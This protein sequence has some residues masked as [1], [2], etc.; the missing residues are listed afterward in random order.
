MVLGRLKFNTDSYGRMD[1]K[2]RSL[3]S[4]VFLICIYVTISCLSGYSIFLSYKELYH[5]RS[6]NALTF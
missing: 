2:W 6:T 1:L 3:N 4:S 5:I